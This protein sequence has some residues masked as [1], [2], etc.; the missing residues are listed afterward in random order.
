MPIISSVITSIDL[1]PTGRRS[2]RRRSRRT[3]GRRSRRRR[4]P[5]DASVPVSGS[6]VG[7]NSVLKTS[8]AAV[9]YRKKSYHSM[10]VPTKLASA[11]TATDPSR[12]AVVTAMGCAILLR[13]LGRATGCGLPA[14]GHRRRAS[15]LQP[16]APSLQASRPPGLQAS[17]PPGLHLALRQPWLHTA[18]RDWMG[19]AVPR[20]QHMSL[21]FARASR[22]LALAAVMLM[23][24]LAA[25]PASAQ[26]RATLIA[27]GLT[28][29]LGFVQHP[30]DPA[31]QVVLE[32][33]GRIRVLR[34]GTLESTPFLDLRGLTSGTGRTG[35]ARS[36]LCA[37]LRHERPGVRQFHEQRRAFGGGTIHPLGHRSI[38]ARSSEPVRSAVARRPACHHPAIFQ[39]QRR[40]PGLRS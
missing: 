7:K 17:R 2:G 34:G 5:N 26:L 37:R 4:W 23:W 13:R 6:N 15:S 27:D 38:A 14:T 10:V 3:A 35:A 33:A 32:Q 25:V 24:L 31:V 22:H 40:Q 39:P 36:G 28:R 9:P 18:M 11:T 29:P 19:R 30:T 12:R 1:R 20:E 16:R 21:P 8:A